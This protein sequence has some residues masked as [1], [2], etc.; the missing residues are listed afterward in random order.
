MTAAPESP[1]EDAAK[2]IAAGYA[3]SGPALQLGAVV[4]GGTPHASAQVRVPL[5]M[6]NRHGLIAGATGTGRRRPCS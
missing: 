1:A 6:L 3:A 4:V 5:S 2:R